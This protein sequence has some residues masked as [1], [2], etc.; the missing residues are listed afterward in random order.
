[1]GDSGARLIRKG[2]GG[3]P[4]LLV[5]TDAL[6]RAAVALAG[7]GEAFGRAAA[8]FPARAALGRTAF[9]SLPAGQEAH[10][11]YAQTL[12]EAREALQRITSQVAEIAASLR[13]SA[14]N[15]DGADS[16]SCV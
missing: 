14:D 13:Q 2:S 8:G 7:G 16:S 5:D 15:Y 10:G 11:Q 4:D 12:D 6:R 9:G 1:V 3:Q